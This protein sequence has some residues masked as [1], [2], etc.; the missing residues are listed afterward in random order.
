MKNI[1]KF[2]SNLICPFAQRANIALLEG[3]VNFDF[4]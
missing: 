3:K 2:Y 4:I 1:P